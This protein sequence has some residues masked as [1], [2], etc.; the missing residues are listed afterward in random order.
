MRNKIR[1]RKTKKREREREV[2]GLSYLILVAVLFLSILC[3]LLSVVR[4][5]LLFITSSFD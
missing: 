3:R 1:K 2:G 5:L 4:S